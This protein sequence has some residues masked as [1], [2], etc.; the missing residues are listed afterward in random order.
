MRRMRPFPCSRWRRPPTHR[1][2]IYHITSQEEESEIDAARVIREAAGEKV[3]IKDN[4]VGL[5]QKTVL[6][7]KL[8]EREFGIR[9]RYSYRTQAPLILRHMQRH[10]K[11][12]A[13][14]GRGRAGFFGRLWERCRTT[15]W[16]LVPFAENFLAF[17]AVFM[18]NNRTADSE[19][20]RYLDVFLLYVV[21]FAVFYGK[22]QGIV[23][24]LLSVAGFLFRQNYYRQ[25]H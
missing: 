23:A 7:G 17:I 11:Q 3:L 20:V 10:P 21:L 19:F 12:F 5:T 24:A 1:D 9:A 18:I 13:P 22:R 25:G 4:T 15:F 6:S 2:A 16:K 14:R 8:L